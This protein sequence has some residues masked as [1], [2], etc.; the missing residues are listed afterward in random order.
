MSEGDTPSAMVV[1][2]KALIRLVHRLACCIEDEG[3]LGFAAKDFVSAA[4]THLTF[5]RH[6]LENVGGDLRRETLS[7]KHTI[8]T[9]LPPAIRL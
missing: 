6:R 3:L 5:V 1:C 4:L 8:K 9:D 2:Y 7:A